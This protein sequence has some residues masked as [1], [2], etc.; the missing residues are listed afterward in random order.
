MT[1][2]PDQPLDY[3]PPLPMRKRRIVRRIVVGILV[4]LTTTVL[5]HQGPGLWDRLS[6]YYFQ[7]KCMKYSAAPD[8]VVVEIENGKVTNSIVAS[9]WKQF[10]ALYSPPGFQSVATLFLHGRTP[11]QG[12]PILVA[13]DLSVAGNS[14][15]N[16]N[17]HLIVVRTFLPGTPVRSARLFTSEMQVR[18]I[19]AVSKIFAGQPDPENPQHFTI[20]MQ[21]QDGSVNIWDGWLSANDD[22]V[23]IQPRTAETTTP[24]APA[25]ADPPR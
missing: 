8:T 11:R 12:R 25:S 24:P 4:V 9:E 1:S 21:M 3:A 23:K 14:A 17:F 20:K 19:G 2:T 6:L 18:Q 7:Q 5:F 15:A 16:T 22:T 10:Y 13:V